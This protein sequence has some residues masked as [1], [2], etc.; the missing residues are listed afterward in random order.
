M[1]CR[2]KPGNDNWV[3]ARTR[4]RETTSMTL[5]LFELVGVDAERP[6]S[7]FCWRIRMALAHKGLSAETIP[8]CFTEKDAI[9][10]HKS[11][12]VP[13]LLDGENSFADSWAM[14]N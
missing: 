11:E 3:E 6:F 7:P 8:W 1:D 2:V 4:S 10:P 13:V 12:K 9:A 5:K 14:P